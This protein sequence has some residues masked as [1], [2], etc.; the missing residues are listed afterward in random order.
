[1]AVEDVW[2]AGLVNVLEKLLQP[3][4]VPAREAARYITP[5]IR[6]ALDDING[7]PETVY[8]F[9]RALEKRLER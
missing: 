9:V 7:S 5:A 8:K 6:E 1:M 2:P 3:A 4:P